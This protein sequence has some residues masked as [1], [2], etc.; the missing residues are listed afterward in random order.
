MRNKWLKFIKNQKGDGMIGVMISSAVLLIMLT[1]IMQML[2]QNLRSQKGVQISSEYSNVVA[3]LTQ[4]VFNLSSCTEALAGNLVYSDSVTCNSSTLTTLKW[5]G[6]AEFLKTGQTYKGMVFDRFC[7]K[8]IN[9]NFA[10]TG[11]RYSVRMELGASKDPSYKSYG[12]VNYFQE[13]FFTVELDSTNKV[14][15]CTNFL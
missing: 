8:K 10:L 4:I 7:L 13:F 2:D 11:N 15:S 3:Q 5:D 14:V 9:D 12:K 6:N 1:A